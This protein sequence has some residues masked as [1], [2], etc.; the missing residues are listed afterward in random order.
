MGAYVGGP[1]LGAWF[2]GFWHKFAHEDAIKQAEEYKDPEYE[3]LLQQ[4]VYRP[5]KSLAEKVRKESER[6]AAQ[7]TEKQRQA[8]INM[9]KNAVEPLWPDFDRNGSG[10]IT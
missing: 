3:R 9:F 5:R 4:G 8:K 7:A 6:R 10:Y 2:A 1:F